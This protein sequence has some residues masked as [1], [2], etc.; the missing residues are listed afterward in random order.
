MIKRPAYN[1]LRGGL[2]IDT[3]LWRS[4]Y[5]GSSDR[6]ANVGGKASFSPFAD[7]SPM[8]FAIAYR[9]R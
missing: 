7:R 1:L 8:V 9:A 4:A 3:R 2:R 5:S 6:A